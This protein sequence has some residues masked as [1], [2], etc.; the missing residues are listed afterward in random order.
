MKLREI[1]YRDIDRSINP[2]VVVS[3]KDQSVIEA[4]IKEY[5][6]TDDIIEKLFEMLNTVLNKRTGK[7][8]IWINGYYGSGKSHFIKYVHYLLSPDTSDLAF[9]E[10]GKA[11]EAYDPMKPENNDDIT[12]ANLTLLQKKIDDTT[13]DDIMFNV[14]DETDDG[15]DERMTRIFLNMFN[16]FRGYNSIDI[17]LALLLEKQIDRAG[18]FEE[19]KEVVTEEIGES[20]EQEAAQIAAFALEDVLEIAKRLVPRLDTTSLY[21]RLSGE[22]PFPISISSTLIPEFQEYIADKG[23]NYRLLFLVDEVSQ[24]VGTNKE[25]LLN[26]QNIIER[27]GQ[28]CNNQIWIACTAQQ[29]LDEVSS[30]TMTG[31][32][33]QDEFGKILGR[34]DTRISLQSND[35]SFI[36]QKRVLNKNSKGLKAISEIYEDNKDYIENQ[37]R[38]NHELF[39]GYED[40]ES[41][42]VAY[43]FVPYQFRLISHVFEAFQAL[44]YVI[45]EVTDNERSVLGITHFTAKDCADM[46]VGSFVPFDAFYNAQFNTNLTAQGN[47]AIQNAFEL[48]YVE[49]SPFAQRV[50]KVLF[51]ISNLLENQRQTFPSNIEN[52]AV[53]LMDEL[54]QNRKA[55]YDKVKV[56]LDRLLENNIIREENGSYFYFN[57]D[58]IE[59]QNLIKNQS[60]NLEDRFKTFNDDFFAPMVVYK[61]KFS[62]GSKDFKLGFSI[63]DLKINSGGDFNLTVLYS[64]NRDITQTALNTP[65]SDLVICINEWFNNDQTLK[66]DFIWYCKTNK[67]FI[68]N[69]G[70]TGQ[71]QSTIDSFKIRNNELK[72][73]IKRRIQS[74]FT[75][76]RF[77]SQQVIIE[78]DQVAGS[79]P[80]DRYKNIL[81]RHL[82]AIYDKHNLSQGYAKNSAE[83]KASAASAQVEQEMLLPAEVQVDDFIT[84]LGGQATVLD[85]TQHFSKAPFGWRDEALIDILTKLVKKK[86]REF[87]YNNQ[88]RYGVVDFVN[89][90]L[91]TSERSSCEVVTG[92]AVNQQLLNNVISAHRDVFNEELRETTDGNELFDLLVESLNKTV[93]QFHGL[94]DSYR[95]YAF[96]AAFSAFIQD[97][98]SLVHIRDPKVLFQN[99]VDKQLPL[100]EK[101]DHAEKIADW[102]QR[103]L[104]EFDKIK[105]FITSNESNL[106]ELDED[107][108]EIFQG[109]KEYLKSE[110]PVND[111]RH[112]KKA[113]EELEEYLNRRLEDVRSQVEIAFLELYEELEREAETR[114]VSEDSYE[115]KDFKLKS[116][117]Q[118]DSISSLRSIQYGLGAYKEQEITKIINTALP[119]GP[120]DATEVYK[121]S[122]K[123]TVISNKEELE[124][125]LD[126]V[127]NEMSTL[128]SQNKTII[129]K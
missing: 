62:F 51:M 30:G 9:K 92:E 107:Q 47:N 116:I 50:V 90:A 59:V 40:R 41:F 52:I 54:D 70:S 44:R 113:K 17:P 79:L 89:K 31:G 32:N 128:L 60:I 85:L 49:D 10:L 63:E 22:V 25:I 35:A 4:E 124:E 27:V 106:N 117:K 127:K 97:L 20:W 8:G 67:Y 86:K 24:Y 99:F 104:P 73:S 55:L 103:A 100:K 91:S 14:E 64:D 13:C 53:L 96:S 80:K 93:D 3:Q 84:S 94:N 16:R 12:I 28:D 61:S 122:S 34:F 88:P 105:T 83:L 39:K 5:V 81:D 37:F 75:E 102:A 123:A 74:K 71:R 72:E 68:A 118:A 11:V 69:T 57:E 48:S 114:G 46:E 125:Y 109:L 121:I 78:S 115:S 76:T 42:E 112:K 66:T 65:K 77:I 29:S 38:I 110:T 56:V 33:I 129:L 82:G 21:N 119:E 2:A 45:R 87:K 98:N 26:F 108:K 36:T 95:S 7:T 111:F 120:E 18:K 126:K 23:A 19:F 101:R 1:Y 58:E 15:S 6:F 43:P